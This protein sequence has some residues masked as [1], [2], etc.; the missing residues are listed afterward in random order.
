MLV[1]P[2]APHKIGQAGL[3]MLI[4]C[5]WICQRFQHPPKLSVFHIQYLDLQ[6][7]RDLHLQCHIEEKAVWALVK[8]RKENSLNQHHCHVLTWCQQ[9]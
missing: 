7:L 2:Q 8:G 5:K 1:L 3:L 9:W 4:C 6:P